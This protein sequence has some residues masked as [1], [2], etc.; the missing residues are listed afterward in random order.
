MADQV[1]ITPTDNGPL[2]VQGSFKIV[3][4]SGQALETGEET[5]LCRCGASQTKPFCDGTHS[6]VG[7]AAA[8]AAAAEVEAHDSPF[9][10][11]A[12]VD[13]VG[14]GKLLGVKVAGQPVVLGCLDGELYAIG[15]I[16][17]HG[18]APLAEGTLEDGV[19]LCPYHRGGFNL[20][21]GAA[22]RRPAKVPVPRYDVKV[23]GG[24]IVVARQPA[25]S[26]GS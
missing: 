4:P 18:G 15:G 13:A 1:I 22:V 21:T 2:Q 14:E 17:T 26:E 6:H 10:A 8:E 3:Q 24:Q 25:S 16:C 20:K 7:F 5:W 9:Q 23:E 12:D 19:V 11:V